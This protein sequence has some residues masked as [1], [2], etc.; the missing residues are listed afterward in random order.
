MFGNCLSLFFTYFWVCFLDNFGQW[1][2][3]LVYCRVWSD[4]GVVPHVSRNVLL[5]WTFLF[6]YQKQNQSSQSMLWYSV[7]NKSFSVLLASSTI[8]SLIPWSQKLKGRTYNDLDSTG[9]PYIFWGT[10]VICLSHSS[11]G[12]VQ[13]QLPVQSQDSV[14]FRNFGK[15]KPWSLKLR[16]K[17]GWPARKRK[18]K[19]RHS[20]DSL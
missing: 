15:W 3:M 17:S 6:F 5:T 19:N 8:P 2:D 7:F 4:T 14:S 20:L 18:R 1:L 12:R 10:T 16:T 9:F 11:L 13:G